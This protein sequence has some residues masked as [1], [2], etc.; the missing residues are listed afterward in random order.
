MGR[1]ESNQTKSNKIN[2]DSYI[3]NPY[4]EQIALLVCAKSSS[5]LSQ[6]PK[7]VQSNSQ[8][9]KLWKLAFSTHTPNVSSLSL[10][11]FRPWM[12]YYFIKM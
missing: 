10:V 9:T 12:Q 6:P 1:K 11:L 4:F 8:F 7:Y 5:Q 2:L 3:D